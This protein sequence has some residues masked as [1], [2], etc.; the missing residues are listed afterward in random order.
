M[1]ALLYARA[2]EGLLPRISI[3]REY[4]DKMYS[5]PEHWNAFQSCDEITVEAKRMSRFGKRGDP[6]CIVRPGAKVLWEQIQ[7]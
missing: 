5:H 4:L 7:V 6:N 1:A 2:G 3:L